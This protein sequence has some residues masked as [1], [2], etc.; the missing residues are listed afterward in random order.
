M[1]Y[2]I[3]ENLPNPESVIML[4]ERLSKFNIRIFITNLFLSAISLF[5][6]LPFAR[7]ICNSAVEG[8]QDI[9]FASYLETITPEMFL[10]AFLFFVFDGIYA[11]L[12]F[13]HLRERDSFLQTAASE[14][15][16]LPAIAVATS[17]TAP[18]RSLPPMVTTTRSA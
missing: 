6:A 10:F 14:V 8:F 16:L 11:T 9:R 15:M 3:Q 2:C 12:H 18:R 5:V 1:I 13:Y 4:K 17:G 7:G